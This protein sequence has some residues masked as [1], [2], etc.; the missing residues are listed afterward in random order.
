[1]APF[2]LICP[3]G[4]PAALRAAVDAGADAVYAGFRD[5]TNARNFPGLNFSREEMAE[6]IRYARAR[7]RMLFVAINTY[8]AAGRVEPWRRAVDDAARL[9]ADAVILADLGLLDYAARTHPGLRLHLSVQ[10]SASNAEA[11][12]FYREA[13]GVRRVVLPRVLTVADIR[14]LVAG[15]DVETEVFV[16]GGMCPM[17]E[18]R[19]TLSSYA[20]GRSP[21]RQGV[22][23]PAEHV[24]YEERG[25][26]LV[27]RLGG[28]TINRFA[29]G[30]PAGYPT[31][32]KGRFAAA[33]KASYLFEEPTSLNALPL[34]P[35]LHEAGVKAL[36]IEGR[37]RG[38]AYVAAV[39]SAYR[40]AIDGFA[41][42]GRVD[43]PGLD[44]GLDGAVEGGR[45][46]AGAYR[47]S[48]R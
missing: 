31:L 9:G 22:C 15:T 30:E 16:F 24:R 5:E 10:A 34:L 36:K 11:V 13:F 12:R 38:K 8:P 7:G 3:A 27:S 48:W 26:D 45:D 1:M 23:S 19:C 43:D 33:G 47:R 29:A 32:C 17:A 46:T 6:G 18:G 44:A 4:T 2:E 28:F 20:T 21:N 41:R 14:G 42:T 39:V 40:R 35:A 25:E 37:Q